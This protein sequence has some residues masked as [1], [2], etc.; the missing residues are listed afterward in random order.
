MRIRLWDL[1]I[2]ECVMALY[3]HSD[4]VYQCVFSRC[5]EYLASG[6]WDTTVRI[7]KIERDQ[8]D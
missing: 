5:G 4:Q 6:S 2:G 7:W 3:E 1:G 8:E